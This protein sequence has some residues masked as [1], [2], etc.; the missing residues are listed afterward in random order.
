MAPEPTKTEEK[1]KAPQVAAAPKAAKVPRAKV[2]VSS[3]QDEGTADARKGAK[4]LGLVVVAYI[5]YLV[6]SGQMGT[7]IE[8][9]S[10]VDRAWIIGAAICYVFYFIFGVG[11]YAVAVWLDHDSPVGFRDLMSVEASGVFFGN[12]TP[13]MAGAVPAQIVRLTRTGLDAGEAMAT[14][15]TR[16]IVFQFAVVL[17]A[18]IMLLAKFQFFLETYGD[19]VFLNLVVFAVHFVELVVLFVVCLMPGFVKRI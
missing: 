9:L 7:F 17:F 19:I 8:A 13:M 12:L 15:F 14:Q 11:A 1:A 18:A 4:F 2:Q 16:F 3:T 6:L 5:V 10:N